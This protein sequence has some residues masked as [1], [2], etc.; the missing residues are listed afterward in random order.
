MAGFRAQDRIGENLAAKCLAGFRP[1]DTVL[2]KCA[3]SAEPKTKISAVC[4]KGGVGGKINPFN[5]IKP[6]KT[7][8][9]TYMNPANP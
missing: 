2:G 3:L 9:Q 4:L 5:L 8:K 7:F 6:D 1:D